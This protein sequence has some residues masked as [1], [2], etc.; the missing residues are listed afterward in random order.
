VNFHD[1]A[2]WVLAKNVEPALPVRG[3]ATTTDRLNL[4]TGPS[5][6]DRIL[7]TMSTGA[8]VRLTGRQYHGFVSVEYR[9]I[10][11]WT[12]GDYLDFESPMLPTS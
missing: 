5:T 7:L 2:G 10:T 3:T 1:G 11:G 6:D 4:R 8:L 12:F 9:G